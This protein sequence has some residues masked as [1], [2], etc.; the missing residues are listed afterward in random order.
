MEAEMENPRPTLANV[1]QE[2]LDM[3]LELG[4]EQSFARARE[5][6]NLIGRRLN[7]LTWIR[8][9]NIGPGDL[10]R[11][12]A[13]GMQEAMLDAIALQIATGKRRGVFNVLEI[14][15]PARLGRAGERRPMLLNSDDFLLDWHS[16]MLVHAWANSLSPEPIMDLK[17]D[18]RFKGKKACDF[19]LPLPS[20]RYELLECKRIHPHP[21]KVSSFIESAVQKLLQLIPQ[22][23]VQFTETASVIGS[24][25]CNYHL[26]IDITA[27]AG[28]PREMVLPDFRVELEG[29]D[30]AD[31]DLIVD[32]IR[33]VCEELRQV[34]LCWHTPV[35]IDG[36][37]CAI[38]QQPRKVLEEESDKESPDYP[39]W[40]VENYPVNGTAY[41]ELRVA[42]SAFSVNRIVTSYR[43]FSNPGAFLKIAPVEKKSED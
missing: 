16:Q 8:D 20:G 17:L 31:I 4:G 22:A 18:S 11:N 37:P 24:D 2:I 9:E 6:K 32:E 41:R 10:D 34:T 36:L 14:E 40:T 1:A 35:R 21:S 27:Y 29:L 33:P 12:S 38:L 13:I 43:M 25:Q 3:Y 5:A 30:D 42:N 39:G 7:L 23:I 26:L 28:D 15:N 19:A